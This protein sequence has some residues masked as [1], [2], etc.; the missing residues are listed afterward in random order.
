MQPPLLTKSLREMP[1]HQLNVQFISMKSAD[2]QRREKVQKNCA[3][4]SRHV[5]QACVRMK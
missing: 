5:M 1:T 4:D 3:A 2:A